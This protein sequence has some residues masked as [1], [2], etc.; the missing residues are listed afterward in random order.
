MS[1]A[2]AYRYFPS[3]S[4]LVSVVVAEGLAPVR[5]FEP[6]AAD[7]L[8]RVRELFDKTFPL[9]KEYEPHYRD[10]EAVARWMLEALIES[11][12]RQAPAAN[13]RR[14]GRAAARPRAIYRPRLPQPS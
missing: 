2:T 14:R 8:G 11:A 4:K 6:K 13:G 3:R 9:F 1:R 10:V 5:R 7:G 12:L